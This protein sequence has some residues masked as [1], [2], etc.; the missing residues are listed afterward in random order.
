M[1][2]GSATLRAMQRRIVHLCYAG[3]SGASRVAL[4]IAWGCPDPPRHAYVLLGAT[5]MRAD[6]A[7]ELDELGCRWLFVRKRRGLDWMG[8]RRAAVAIGRLGPAAAVL[9]GSRLLPVALWLRMMRRRLPLVGVQHG[10]TRELTDNR[11]RWVCTA[12]STVVDGTITVSQAMADLIGRYPLLGR[13]CSPLVVIHNGVDA[14]YWRAAPPRI[15]AGGPL[16][17]GMVA[18]MESYKD[19]PT[20]LRAARM[21]IDRGRAVSLHLVGSGPREPALHDLAA[22]LGLEQAVRFEGGRPQDAVRHI[23]H[24]LDVLVHAT[25]SESL[26]MAV[27]EAMSSARP[28]VATDI[29]ALREVI[30]DGQ[31]GLLVPVGD[32]E[33]LA[34]AVARLADDPSLATR[35]GVAARQYA[36]EH[37]GIAR[38]ARAY[39]Q[40]VDSLDQSRPT[41]KRA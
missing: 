20:L 38:M 32:A 5:P 28:I 24:G 12:F 35:L 15:Q 29:A 26:G 6:Y 10:P 4:N 31:T 40:L 25:H 18:A 21:L 9:H 23:V 8:Y 36:A 30:H 14:E 13:A 27:V 16:V 11:Y 17:I 37:F 34:G 41:A 19:H 33:A 2:W 1:P 22:K 7:A 3:T 39:E